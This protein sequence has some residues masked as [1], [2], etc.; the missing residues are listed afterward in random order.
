MLNIMVVDDS[1]I[2][3]KGLTTILKE[4]GFNVV[5]EAGTG[6]EAV[7]LYDMLKPDLVTMDITMPVMTGNEA[8]KR[9]KA[10]HPDAKIIM[11]TSHGEEQLV[12]EAILA[13]AKGYVLKP[14]TQEKLRVS[15]CKVV[16]EAFIL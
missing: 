9:I 4:L 3:R 2:I 14:I 10:K 5:G 1:M 12:M 13:G 15:L 11:I 7:A 16:P 6:A 8:L